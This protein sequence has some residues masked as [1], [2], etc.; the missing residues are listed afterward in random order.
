MRAV[1]AIVVAAACSQSAEHAAT[2]GSAATPAP[3]APADAA[4]APTNAN[5]PPEPTAPQLECNYERRVSCV[6]RLDNDRP[7]QP[8][9]FIG[10]PR[11]MSRAANDTT[12]MQFSAAETR[13]AWTKT[14]G[15][16]CYV[17]FIARQ[18]R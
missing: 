6:R 9:P 5:D 16:C 11:T 13:A 1:L 18:C 12:Q 8:P 17:D 7:Y 10:C 14:P 3:S 2:I 15:V 4:V